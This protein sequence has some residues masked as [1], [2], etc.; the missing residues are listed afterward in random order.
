MSQR[1]VG[2]GAKYLAGLEAGAEDAR[3]GALGL[4]DGE[5]LAAVLGARVEGVVVDAGAEFGWEGQEW[6]GFAVDWCHCCGWSVCLG[7]C[8]QG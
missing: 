2:P 4:A 3:F 1:W 5:V 6:A 7:G 8:E